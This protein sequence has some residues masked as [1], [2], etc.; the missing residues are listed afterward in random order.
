M[1]NFANK[2]GAVLVKKKLKTKTKDM[3]VFNL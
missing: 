3:F 1:C 2:V